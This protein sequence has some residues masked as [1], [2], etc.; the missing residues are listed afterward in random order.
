MT[1][2][3]THGQRH[4]TFVHNVPTPAANKCKFTAVVGSVSRNINQCELT[5]RQREHIDYFKAR[6]Q[7]NEYSQALRTLNVDVIEAEAVDCY[8]DCCF[9]QDTA[10]VLDEIC[11]IASMGASSRVGEVRSM[12]TVL[13]RFRRIRRIMPPATLDGGDVIQLG[14]QIFVGASRRTNARGITRFKELVE[15]Y[16]YKLTPVDVNGG[17]HLT[18]GCGIVNDETVIVNP[19]WLDADAF[20]GLRRLQVAED[21]P[22]AANTIRVESTVCVEQHAPK[23]LDQIQPYISNVLT[24][25]ISEFRKAEGS[26]SCLSL[27]FN[28]V[29]IS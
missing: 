23:T 12:E 29:E 26:L 8:P 4:E 21:E 25:D 6:A 10:V 22:W 24:L 9:V 27:I 14:R 5:Y 17:L 7:L 28:K 11:V 15:P 16:G 18:T 20:K 1:F 13:S 2:L 19:R 3:D